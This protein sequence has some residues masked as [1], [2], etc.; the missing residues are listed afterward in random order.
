MIESVSIDRA[1]CDLGSIMSLMLYSIL[2]TLGLGELRPINISLRLGN[3]SI[4]YPLGILEDVSIKMGEFYVPIDFVVL[5]MAEDSHT[6]II[7]S[8]PF[9]A[10]AGC[11]IDVKEGKLTFDVGENHGKFGLFRDCEPFPSTFSCCGCEMLDVDKPVHMLDMSS[12]N[13]PSINC[14]LFKGYGLDGLTV[15]SLPPSIIKDEQY[16]VDEGYLS[17]CCKFMTLLISMPLMS[18]GEY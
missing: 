6:Q 14:T 10:I 3:H 9:L 15:D 7:L 12:N 1:L 5:D 17:D 18:G 13:P 2:K 4:K 11:K 8:R 16:A